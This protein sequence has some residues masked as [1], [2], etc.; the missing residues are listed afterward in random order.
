ML[1]PLSR[2]TFENI[3][4]MAATSSQY[5]YCWGKPADALRRL[6]ISLAGVFGI[7]LLRFFLGESFDVPLF[8]AG[9]VMVCYWL[10][11]PVYFATQRNREY[12]RYEFSGF[13]SGEVVDKF[14]TEELTGTQ[15]TVDKKGELVVIENRERRLNLEVG[16]ETGF[17]AR[18]QVPLKREY[19][20]IRVGDWAEMLV[21]SNRPDL[22]RI[23]KITDVYVPDA[24]LWVSDYPY[25]RRDAFKEVSK[26]LRS[27]YT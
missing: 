18:I 3:I 20:N 21:L 14:V 23:M 25:L 27:E 16:D 26:R 22:S 2:K 1:I 15:E 13:W 9:A 17:S 19:R 10:W 8:I 12:R 5:R 11:A 4:P 7:L 6:L 24:N